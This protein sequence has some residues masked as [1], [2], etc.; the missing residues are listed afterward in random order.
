M[1]GGEVAKVDA[2]EV[3]K[4]KEDVFCRSC[5]AGISKEAEICP[6][7]GVRQRSPKNP[8]TAALLSFFITGAGQIYNGEVGKGIV[9]IVVQIINMFLVAVVIGLITLP[10]TW[11][12]GIYDAYK[13]AEKLNQ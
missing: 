5:G 11:L 6:K 12:Y 1:T 13:T 9:F 8:S 10:A 3:A 2:G 7:C 4:I